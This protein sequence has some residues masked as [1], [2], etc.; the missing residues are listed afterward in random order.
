MPQI[1]DALVLGAGIAGCSAAIALA[2]RGVRVELVEREELWRFASSGIFVYSN[3]LEAL[4]RIG[5][6][7]EILAAG[8]PVESGRNVY[9]DSEGNHIVDVHYPSGGPGVPPVVGIKRAEL[10]RILVARLSDLGVAVRLGTTATGVRTLPDGEG[11]EIRLSDGSS[12]RAALVIGAEG[13]R[14][15]LRASVAG[16]VE[17]RFTGFGVWRSVHDRPRDIDVKIMMMGVGKRLGIMP[18]S[19]DKLYLFGTV[20]EPPGHHHPR[21]GWPRAMQDEFA[22][23]GG[24]ARPFL[25]EL[26]AGSEVIYTAVEEVAAAPPWHAGR[27]VLVGDAAHA[28]TPFMGQGGAMAVEDGVVLADLLSRDGD[29]ETTLRAFGERRHP[30]CAFVQEASRAVGEAGAV[31]DPVSCR[32]RDAAMRVSAQTQ[33]DDFYARLNRMDVYP[34]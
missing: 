6:L 11:A 28:S 23:F 5:V 19:E 10:H 27:V 8:F 22:E 33:V 3:G 30:R 20:G 18:I 9:L 21:E 29:V 7:P 15:P 1:D 13:I 16:P 24:P 17:P 34:R 12:R 26:S 32:R 4:R 31:E 2:D 14:S 25:E